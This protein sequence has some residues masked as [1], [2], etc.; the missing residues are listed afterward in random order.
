VFGISILSTLIVC[1][2]VHYHLHLL[3]ISTAE[4]AHCINLL[5]RI[6]YSGGKDNTVRCGSPFIQAQVQVQE[7][8]IS[9]GPH[10]LD[11][12]SEMEASPTG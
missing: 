12:G 3:I 5:P 2:Q 10:H 6:Q 7:V 9:P 4:S 1:F 8:E 11:V